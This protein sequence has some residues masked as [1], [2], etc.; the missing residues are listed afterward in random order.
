M[1]PLLFPLLAA[2]LCGATQPPSSPS[3]PN[4]TDGL[5]LERDLKGGKTHV[6]PV[7]LQ[8]GQF[9]RVRVQEEGIDLAVRL[10]DPQGAP[11]TGVDTPYLPYMNVK[12]S[13]RRSGD[14]GASLWGVQPGNQ[15]VSQGPARPV[16]VD[17]G[18]ATSSRGGRRRGFSPERG[19]TVYLE[20]P[21]GGLFSS[22]RPEQRAE[23]RVVA[24]DRRSLGA[25]GRAQEGGGNVVLP[26]ERVLFFARACRGGNS[27]FSALRLPL[28]GRA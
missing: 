21:S 27:E 16:S 2:L 3:G 18:G 28:E 9:L 14:S 15:L 20:N 12:D 4:L 11:T 26:W 8:A 7:D 19:G 1:A 6:Y 22:T 25:S 10:L 5:V 24:T 23:D 13:S 17:G